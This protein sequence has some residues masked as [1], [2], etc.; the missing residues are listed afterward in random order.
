MVLHDFV[1]SSDEDYKAALA[2]VVRF[3]SNA[4]TPGIEQAKSISMLRKRIL[5]R[6][7][8]DYLPQDSQEK[9]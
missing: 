6:K 1:E 7:R 3:V 2:A 9:K 4:P 5:K 8:R